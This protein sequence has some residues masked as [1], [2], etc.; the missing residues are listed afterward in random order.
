MGKA[1]NT[2]SITANRGTRAIRVVKV[3]LL[4]V[5]P[6]WSSRKRSRKVRAV[7]S[8]GQVCRVVESSVTRW[9]QPARAKDKLIAL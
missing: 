4:A 1:L 8:Q 2:A 3:R 7:S 5:K 6:R 9:R